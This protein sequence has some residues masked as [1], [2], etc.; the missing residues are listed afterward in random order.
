MSHQQ[1]LAQVTAQAVQ[2]N[3]KMHNQDET[4][5]SVSPTP[6]ATSN[7]G[8]QQMPQHSIPDSGATMKECPD[9]GFNWRKYGQKQVKGSEFPRS[10]YKCTYPNCP[11]KKK[12]ER[13]IDDDHVVSIIYKGQHSHQPIRPIKREKDT[14][15]ATVANGNLKLRRDLDLSSQV[16]DGKLKEGLACESVSSDSEDAGDHETGMEDKNDEPDPKRRQG[17]CLVDLDVFMMG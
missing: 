14:T 17:F 12:V 11:V 4:P 13:S 5:S 3:L 10:Y 2:A 9:D 16:H 7:T 15:A 8:Q 1:A 6:A